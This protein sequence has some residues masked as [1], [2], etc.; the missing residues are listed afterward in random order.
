MEKSSDSKIQ[1]NHNPSY[2][3][4]NHSALT[5]SQIK[6]VFCE[7]FLGYYFSQSTHLEL[8]WVSGKWVL[9]LSSILLYL[10]VVVFLILF[11]RLAGVCYLPKLQI[12]PTP[13]PTFITSRQENRITNYPC[14]GTAFFYCACAQARATASS[15]DWA[16]LILGEVVPEPL[17]HSAVSSLQHSSRARVF[18]T[19]LFSS[20][21]YNRI[22]AYSEQD[23]Y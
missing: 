11:S 20:F 5:I 6:T 15:P 23:P 3:I 19:H 9:A 13:V 4:K 1:F 10:T 18:S 16:F 17:C 14:L 2:L 21:L 22:W 7:L 12:P 8:W